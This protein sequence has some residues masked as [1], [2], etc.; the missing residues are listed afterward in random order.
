[1]RCHKTCIIAS[2]L[3]TAGLYATAVTNDAAICLNFDRD[4]KVFL[5]FTQ[6]PS[7]IVNGDKL[8][9]N[10]NGKETSEYKLGDIRKITFEPNSFIVDI[11]DA[12]PDTKLL[13]YEVPYRIRLSGFRPGTE[14]AVFTSG[15]SCV[16]LLPFPVDYSFLSI[17]LSGLSP[18]VYIVVAGDRSFKIFL[19][20]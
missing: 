18:G 10:C 20:G 11:S 13:T 9:I 14:V 5:E 15:G 16:R 6:H 7:I 19:H 12:I 8:T 2:L 3:V 4:E 1:M 17:D